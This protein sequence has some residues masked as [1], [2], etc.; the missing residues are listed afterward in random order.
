MIIHV[1]QPGETITSIAEFYNIPV[2]RLI[3][4]N[5]ILNPSNLVIGQ[6]IVIVYPLL[7]HTVTS[8]YSRVFN[9]KCN[10]I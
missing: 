8:V 9:G 3:L 4:E 10:Y 1:V 5:E 7:N 6:T 2:H